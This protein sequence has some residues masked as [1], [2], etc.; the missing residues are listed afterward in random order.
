[1]LV[2]MFVPIAVSGA[3]ELQRPRQA[4]NVYAFRSFTCTTGRTR[5]ARLGLCHAVGVSIGIGLLAT[6]VAT[7]IARWLRSGLVRHEF[8]G[9]STANTVIF[10]PMHHRRS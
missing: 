9:R 7:I 1:V 5:A 8:S 4:K 2:Y 6:L 3:D 10:L